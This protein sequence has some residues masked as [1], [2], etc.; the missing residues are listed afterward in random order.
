MREVHVDEVKLAGIGQLPQ[1]RRRHVGC[2]PAHG[3]GPAELVVAS[4]AGRGP[5]EQADLERRTGVMQRSGPAGKGAGDRLG[6]SAGVKP[7]TPTIAPG[8][9]KAAASSAVRVG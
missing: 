8:G 4:R 9:I 7:L 1:G 2:P 3:L 6:R 5:A